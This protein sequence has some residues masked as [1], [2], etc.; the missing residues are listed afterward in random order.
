[1]GNGESIHKRH[2]VSVLMHHLV[3]SA[4]YRRVVMSKHV[5]N[6][7]RGACLGTPRVVIGGKQRTI[8]EWLNLF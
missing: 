4:K 2:N 5:E 6:E 8:P 7:L 1:M 3:R